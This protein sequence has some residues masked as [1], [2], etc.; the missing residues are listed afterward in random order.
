[1]LNICWRSEVLNDCKGGRG[2]LKRDWMY[3]LVG[4]KGVVCLGGVGKAR[5]CAKAAIAS[6][7]K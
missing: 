6:D 3:C 2:E 7:S 4:F 1:M 5:V